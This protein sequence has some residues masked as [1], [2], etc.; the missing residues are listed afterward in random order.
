MKSLVLALALFV[1][2]NPALACSVEPTYWNLKIMNLISADQKVHEN[3]RKMG[4]V[5]A[6]SE[7]LK[8]N[9]YRVSHG[10]CSFS[11]KPVLEFPKHKPGQPAACPRIVGVD[12]STQIDCAPSR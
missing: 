1:S 2:S 12:V 8:G 9:S 10:E 3:G 7:D 4:G 11:V 6:I 5:T